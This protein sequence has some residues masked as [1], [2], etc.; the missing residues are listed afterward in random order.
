V[1]ISHF[2]DVIRKGTNMEQWEKKKKEEIKSFLKKVFKNKGGTNIDQTRLKTYLLDSTTREI[3]K[4]ILWEQWDGIDFKPIS[5]DEVDSERILEKIHHNLHVKEWQDMKHIPFYRRA[6]HTFS[7]IAAILIFPILVISVWLLIKEGSIT[8]EKNP[9]YAEITS[10]LS[11]RTFFSLPDG[12][13]GWLNSG[14]TLRFPVHFKGRERSVFLQGEGY[15]NV[16]KNPKKPFV[17][18]TDNL[19]I[20]ALGTKFNVQSYVEDQTQIITLE[21]GKLVINCCGN[22]SK[23]K[24]ISTL[25]PGEQILINKENKTVK[26]FKV[27][28]VEYSSWKNGLLIFRSDPMDEVVKKISRW[29]NVSISLKGDEIRTYRYRGTFKDESLDEVL[30]LLKMTS[31]IDY[32]ENKREK[33][34]DGTFKKRKIVLFLKPGYNR[35]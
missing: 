3:T 30:R 34:P 12:S 13:C 18:H 24:R 27:N 23:T 22:S 2:S 15:F 9:S 35:E 10:P 28:P 32:T 26:K 4:Y 6:Y 1:K 25:D 5:K 29:Y 8:H 16:K 7:K 11:A 33:L 20:M 21:S 17:V 31:P 19:K 14:S